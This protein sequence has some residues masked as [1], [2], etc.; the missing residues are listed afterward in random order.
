MGGNFLFMDKIRYAV[1]ADI[2]GNYEAFKTCV[3]YALSKG[4]DKFIFLGDYLGEFP[5]PQD[6]MRLIYK[7]RDEYE[8][9]FIKGNKEDYWLDRKNN[10][11]CE[12]KDGN[13]SV[14]AMKYCYENLTEEDFTFF[15]SLP[16]SMTINKRGFKPILA[17]HGSPTS[18]RE[19]LMEDCEA[20]LE[21]IRN[22][23]DEFIVCGHTHWQRRIG[24]EK[25]YAINVGAVGI[26][27]YSGGKNTQFTILE[28]DSEGY[29]YDFIT[30]DYDYEKEIDVMKASKVY[31]MA[32]SWCDITINVLR[33]GKP[34]NATVLMEALKTDGGKHP[35]YNIPD[36]CWKATLEKMLR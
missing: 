8:C 18:N 32:P 5:N 12:W 14:G 29:D 30:L 1:L 20:T 13:K 3:D 23:K 27:L 22:H 28:G 17:C 11:E 25:E 9:Y 36:E 21:H 35:W 33:K 7:L 24:D 2:H 15:G 34:S 19:K 10:P 4:I 31:E 16:V 6:T 26:A